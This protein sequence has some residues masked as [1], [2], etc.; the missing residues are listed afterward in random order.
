MLPIQHAYSGMCFHLCH[1]SYLHVS[2]KILFAIIV[3]TYYEK[4][5]CMSGKWIEKILYIA[6]K[7]FGQYHLEDVQIL[8]KLIFIVRKIYN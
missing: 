4:T 6:D 3:Y 8:K 1:D 7:Y 2:Q 5:L